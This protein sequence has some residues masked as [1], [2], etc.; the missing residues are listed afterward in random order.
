MEIE[1]YRDL[2]I[3]VVGL[4]VVLAL[5]VLIIVALAL[6][7][8]A[9]K[10]LANAQKLERKIEDFAEYRLSGTK[11]GLVLGSIGSVIGAGFYSY[12]SRKKKQKSNG[13]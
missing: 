4:L 12:Q 7:F 13:K 8:R 11:L 1:W 9:R 10:V 2:S 5:I 6:Y 3:A